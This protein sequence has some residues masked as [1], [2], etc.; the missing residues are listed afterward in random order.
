MLQL[1]YGIYSVVLFCLTYCT[2]RMMHPNT[3]VT[4]SVGANILLLSHASAN[5]KPTKG[6]LHATILIVAGV[7]PSASNDIT[8]LS[9]IVSWRNAH[10][11]A[12]HVKEYAYEY[13]RVISCG[14]YACSV[15]ALFWGLR[16]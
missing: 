10:S 9:H 4:K 12:G 7:I 3:F 5:T 14:G 8:R 1:L 15:L 16:L 13:N 6:S 11:R 2:L